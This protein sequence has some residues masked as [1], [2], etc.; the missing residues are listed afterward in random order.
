L[1]LGLI[2]MFASWPFFSEYF[3]RRWAEP[4]DPAVLTADVS[5]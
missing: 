2:L 1:I 3:R 5:R 4:A